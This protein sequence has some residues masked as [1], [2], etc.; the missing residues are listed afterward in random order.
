MSAP[1]ALKSSPSRRHL[2][3]SQVTD[4]IIQTKHTFVIDTPS[5]PSQVLLLGLLL[6][7]IVGRKPLDNKGLIIECG[8][9]SQLPVSDL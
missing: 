2:A 1:R 6:G 8:D 7:S 4:Q 3:V 5:L 9:P